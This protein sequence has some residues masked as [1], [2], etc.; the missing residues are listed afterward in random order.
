MK[1]KEGEVGHVGVTSGTG[2]REDGKSKD[3]K[4]ERRDGEETKGEM[5]RR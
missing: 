2:K 3:D 5:Q 4:R 1:E